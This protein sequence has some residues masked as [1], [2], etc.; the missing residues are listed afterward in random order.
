MRIAVALVVFAGCASTP[1]PAPAEAPPQNCPEAAPASTGQAYVP[2]EPSA[3]A[4]NLPAV[5][6]LAERAE[7]VGEDFTVWGASLSLRLRFERKWRAKGPISIVGYITKTNLPDAPRCAVHRTG[8]AD[9]PGCTSPVPT[10]WLGDTP[11]ASQ[12][13]SIEV[14]GWASNYAQIH[15]ALRAYAKPGAPAYMD[16]F[17][18]QAVPNPIP[19][20]GAK[21]RVRGSHQTTWNKASSGA[22]ADPIMGILDYESIEVLELAPVPATLPGMRP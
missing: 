12:A 7:R 5:P 17:W 3:V 4:V 19:A 8:V 14:V 1:P 18:G 9:P 13:D 15:D 20:K 11:D 10:F 22:A 16:Q 6:R 21:V 2:R